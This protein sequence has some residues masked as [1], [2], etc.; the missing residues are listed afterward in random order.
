MLCGR[1]DHHAAVVQGHG[2]R[3]L[4]LEIEMVLTT[5]HR[6]APEAARSGIKSAHRVAARHLDRRQYPGGRSDRL[7]NRQDRGQGG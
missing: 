1:V 6:A 3:H 2:E 5:N 4:T 7:F